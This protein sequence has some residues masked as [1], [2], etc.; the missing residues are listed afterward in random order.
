MAEPPGF[1]P[2]R[3]ASGKPSMGHNRMDK[4]EL[5]LRKE[6]LMSILRLTRSLLSIYESSYTAI[7][8]TWRQALRMK[9]LKIFAIEIPLKLKST[10]YAVG[11][12]LTSAP[13]CS[14]NT[15]CQLV[16][17][18]CYHDSISSQKF[19]VQ[20]FSTLTCCRASYHTLIKQSRSSNT[21]QA[22]N[23]DNIAQHLQG[24]KRDRA[25]V[26]QAFI[27]GRRTNMTSLNRA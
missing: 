12:N 23:E 16:A 13:C 19:N 18:L 24:S 3:D 27:L 7:K 20:T 25:V 26:N 21:T 5:N 14:S 10:W 6:N 9:P 2:K 15:T 4:A 11:R 17:R 22:N 1:G 8:K